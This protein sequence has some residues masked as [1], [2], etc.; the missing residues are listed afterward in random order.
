MKDASEVVLSRPGLR[1][2][3]IGGACS[4]GCETTIL[5]PRP[6]RPALLESRVDADVQPVAREPPRLS[7]AP[8]DPGVELGHAM[9]VQ[10]RFEVVDLALVDRALGQHDDIDAT[11]LLTG[12]DQHPIQEVQIKRLRPGRT[13]RTQTG[14]SSASAPSPRPGESRMLAPS[15]ATAAAAAWRT[16]TEGPYR[17]GEPGSCATEPQ[18]P[19]LARRRSVRTPV[20][21]WGEYGPSAARADSRASM[22]ASDPFLASSSRP[23][24]R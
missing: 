21:P 11:G 1:P 15:A 16:R 17:D 4:G 24:A 2:A 7:R 5:N 14:R 3:T 22:R 23:R 13:R 20:V 8:A 6:A 12:G 19:D 9:A 10:Q 18:C